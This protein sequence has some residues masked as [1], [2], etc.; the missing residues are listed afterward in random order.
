MYR[1]LTGY[2]VFVTE[3]L[4]IFRTNNIPFSQLI[5]HMGELWKHLNDDEK[6]NYQSKAR[7]NKLDRQANR[8]SQPS[9][10]NLIPSQPSSINLIQSQPIQVVKPKLVIHPSDTKAPEGLLDECLC[11]ICNENLRKGTFVNCGHHNVC[12]ACGDKLMATQKPC[13][14]CR[15]VG[16]VE[17]HY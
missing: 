15:A 2:Q 8:I 6:E 16:L 9:S 10:I 4:P 17:Y 1:P 7:N 12:V 3:Q 5:T 13:P 14:E 11:I